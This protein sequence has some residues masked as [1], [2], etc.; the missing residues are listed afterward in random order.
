MYSMIRN[1]TYH[2]SVMIRRLLPPDQRR[3]LTEAEENLLEQIQAGIIQPP[4]EVEAAERRARRSKTPI[5]LAVSGLK[6]ARAE[7]AKQAGYT[8]DL[9]FH[10][11]CKARVEQV[12]DPRHWTQAR[13]LYEDYLSYGRAFGKKWAEKIAGREALATETAWGRWMATVYPV[14][15]RRTAGWYY[16]LRIRKGAKR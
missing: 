3:P 15:T 11:W 12:D 16:P 2:T 8:R 13:E 9:I 14:K 4:W 6:Q 1:H 7:L 5:D 10:N